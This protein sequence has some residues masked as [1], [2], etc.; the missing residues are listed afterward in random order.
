MR[1]ARLLVPILLLPVLASC[2]GGKATPSVIDSGATGSPSSSGVDPLVPYSPSPTPFLERTT[3]FIPDTLTLP[4]TGGGK[5]FVTPVTTTMTTTYVHERRAF[6]VYLTIQNPGDALWTGTIGSDAEVTDLNGAVFPPGRAAPGDL[7]PDPARYGGS[8]R[9]LQE[10][11][12]VK[13]GATTAG[14]LVFHVTGGNRPITLRISLDRGA[15]WG[16]WATNLG[17]F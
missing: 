15:T 4:T 11:T 13:P 17:V 12:T 5:L 16:E 14:A 10:R 3:G 7:H 9:S 6:V 2:T 1:R 8:N